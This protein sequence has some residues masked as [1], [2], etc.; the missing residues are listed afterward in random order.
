MQAAA[1]AQALAEN[2]A[3]R[4]VLTG[5]DPVSLAGLGEWDAWTADSPVS[6]V[7]KVYG[8]NTVVGSGFAYGVKTLVKASGTWT[9]IRLMQRTAAT[10]P[11]YLRAGVYNSDGTQLLAQTEELAG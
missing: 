4:H 8:E 6:S 5:A 1:A 10:G 2:H 3:D 7:P 11:T 9:K